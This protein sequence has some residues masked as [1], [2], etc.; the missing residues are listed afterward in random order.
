MHVVQEED[1]L[2]RLVE[3]L[4]RVRAAR[5]HE[6]LREALPVALGLKR[7]DPPAAA[8]REAAIVEVDRVLRR[9]DDADTER[10]RLLEEGEER[11]LRGG[12]GR[13]RKEPEDLVDVDQRAKRGAARL[14]AHPGLHARKQRRHDEDALGVAEVGDGDDRE[15]CPSGGVRTACRSGRQHSP[16][17][18]GL[19]VAER[20]R[21]GRREERVHGEDELLPVLR[22]VERLERQRAHLRERR[23]RR[24]LE[25]R[26][27][28]GG[29]ALLPE[30]RHA[31][32]QEDEVARLHRVRVP[33]RE[34]EEAAHPRGHDVAPVVVVGFGGGRRARAEE[35][36]R[37]S[38]GRARRV[39]DRVAALDQRLHV[40]GSEAPA[41]E[42]IRPL[43]RLG[44]GRAGGRIHEGR[45]LGGR[46][47]REVEHEVAEVALRV[48]RENR[49]TPLQ[50][51][52][53]QDDAERGLTAARHAH[54]QAVGREVRGIEAEVF[55]ARP[56]RHGVDGA[57]EKEAGLSGR[58]RRDLSP[59]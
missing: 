51:L 20:R 55:A 27:E 10:P 52:L 28:R 18:E 56:S 43:L 11:P 54:D 33:P 29:L 7:A 38:G 53:D 40:R 35:V 32:G 36:D 16:D 2:P 49:D 4:R 17:V 37:R 3:K 39:E 14:R 22:G 58:H 26:L 44:L 47:A 9:E 1:P 15:T 8:V 57:A 42:A 48:D 45:E 46:E 25:E 23:R 50:Q 41:A 59:P 30:G 13:G 31:G 5:L 21:R 12:L 19:P 24:G 34:A 6:A